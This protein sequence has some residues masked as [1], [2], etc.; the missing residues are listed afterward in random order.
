MAVVRFHV[1]HRPLCLISLLSQACRS[2]N[3]DHLRI[4]C[5]LL[6]CGYSRLRSTAATGKS[7]AGVRIDDRVWSRSRGHL[8]PTFLG[9]VADRY[10]VPFVLEWIF[11]LPLLGSLLTLLIP[12]TRKLETT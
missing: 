12:D 1:P 8:G 2:G 4:F 11:L 7:G 3:A 10:G 6:L 9:W 5:S